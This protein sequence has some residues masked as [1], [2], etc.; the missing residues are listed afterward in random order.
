MFMKR[1]HNLLLVLFLLTNKNPSV[2]TARTEST[3]KDEDYDTTENQDRRE[4]SLKYNYCCGG[5]GAAFSNKTALQNA[6]N[7][8]VSDSDT[9]VTSYG[10]IGCWN[11]TKVVD[12]SFLFFDKNSFDED[13][14]CWDVSNVIYMAN[15]FSF[16]TSFN[17]LIGYWDVSKVKSMQSMFSGATTFNQAI[18]EWDVSNVKDM[19]YMFFQATS[20]D[21]SLSSWD[22]TNLKYTFSMFAG[23]H[24]YNQYMGG[25]NLG[26]I[27]IM[28][29]MF[30]SATSFN[31]NL[32]PWYKRSMNPTAAIDIFKDTSCSTKD[33]PD[34]SS[35]QSFCQ[36]CVS[37]S[38]S[39][40]SKNIH[41]ASVQTSVNIFTKI[42]VAIVLFVQLMK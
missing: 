10:D 28:S 19:S 9:A 17:Q 11:V 23:A 8:Y 12:M 40:S 32:C 13:I 34:F 29:Y 41:S 7:L 5:K 31:Q 18:G 15:M 16:A 33:D 26:G 36:S 2:S 38:S 24:S 37:S 25:W 3:R 42:V 4:L 39:T 30:Y 27:Q 22:V 6:V 14:G 21:Q 1:R 20:F 35:K